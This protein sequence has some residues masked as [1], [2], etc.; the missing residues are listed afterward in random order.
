MDLAYAVQHAIMKTGIYVRFSLRTGWDVTNDCKP[1]RL[2][3][4]K[5]DSPIA[6]DYTKQ[7]EK[8]L[9]EWLGI[10]KDAKW[11]KHMGEEDDPPE[12]FSNDAPGLIPEGKLVVTNSG[13]DEKAEL[14]TL[15]QDIGSM[16][17]HSN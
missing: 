13:S 7:D 9:K 2:L 11:Y 16:S 6:N 4:F 5:F 12:Y 17:V 15:T 3:A 1:Y 8:R 14:S 10:S